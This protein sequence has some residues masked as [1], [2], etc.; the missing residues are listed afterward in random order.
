MTGLSFTQQILCRPAREGDQTDVVEFCKGIWEG[1]DYVPEV[2]EQWFRDPYGILAVAESNGRVI[3]CSKISG[4]SEG[5]WWLEGFRVDPQC[6][7]M[8]VGSTLH[9]YVVDWWLENGDGALRLM[10]DGQNYPVHHLCGKTGFRK[11][12]EVCGY[13]AAALAETVDHFTPVSDLQTAAAFAVESES[14]QSTNGLSDFGWRI[15]K[16]NKEAFENHSIENGDYFHSFYWWKDRQGL[17]S[18]RE[19]EEEEEK[20]TL[21]LGVIACALEDMPA[22]LMD[23]RRFASVRKFDDI[24]QVAFDLPQIIAPLLAAGFEKKWKRSN[25][26]VFEKIHPSRA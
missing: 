22:L 10:T 16:A 25:A 15:C 1:S 21:I 9:K 2:W 6:Q 5:Q 4:I 7:G 17:F 18:V 26:F 14:I 24:F 19:E 20:K 11:T 8:K 13:R 12:G 23:V 3:G